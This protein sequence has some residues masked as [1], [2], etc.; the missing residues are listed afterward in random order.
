MGNHI[1]P[2]Q[3]TTSSPLII[4]RL[5]PYQLINGKADFLAETRESVSAVKTADICCRRIK[6]WLQNCSWEYH[7]YIIRDSKQTV[8]GFWFICFFKATCV[9]TVVVWHESRLSGWALLSI[10]LIV[11]V[12]PLRAKDTAGGTQ[13]DSRMSLQFLEHACVCVC[14]SRS[15]VCFLPPSSASVSST[16]DME[17]P[18]SRHFFIWAFDFMCFVRFPTRHTHK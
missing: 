15:C 11:P 12:Q 6:L 18:N 14:F 7:D 10:T 16:E 2:S 1:H 8:E 5:F 13:Q 17:T 3:P 4:C 9:S